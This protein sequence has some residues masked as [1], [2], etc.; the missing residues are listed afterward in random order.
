MWRVFWIVAS[1]ITAAALVMTVSRGAFVATLFATLFGILLFRRYMPARK[2]LSWLVW[3]SVG[4]IIAVVLVMS[5]GFGDL[6]YHRVVEG[7]KATSARLPP[8][9]LRSGRTVIE[10][11]FEQPL[12]L[13]TG[14]G[15]EAYRPFPFVGPRITITWSSCST[16]GC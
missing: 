16:L 1:V 11:M 15:W 6:M 9:A 10:V 5:L 8:D 12:T 14:F 2:I 4:A 7:S 3:G 13:L